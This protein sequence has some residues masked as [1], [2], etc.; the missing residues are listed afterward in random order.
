MHSVSNLSQTA[1]GV[2]QQ[3]LPYFQGGEKL[4]KSTALPRDFDAVLRP[5]RRE[6]SGRSGPST[7]GERGE[8]CPPSDRR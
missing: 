2:A 7:V 3:I 4:R 5:L 6:A 8:S 1:I